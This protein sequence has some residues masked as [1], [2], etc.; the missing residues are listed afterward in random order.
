MAGLGLAMGIRS[1][2]FPAWAAQR[3]DPA[4]SGVISALV[5]AAGVAGGLLY[6][7]VPPAFGR[8]LVPVSRHGAARRG[9]L[10]RHALSTSLAAAVAGALVIAWR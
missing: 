10:G 4:L 8:L 9:R 5:S 7:K 1:A 6:G 3:Y 2:V